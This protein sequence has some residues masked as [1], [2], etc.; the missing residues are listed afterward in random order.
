M[1]K[2][3]ARLC[4]CRLPCQFFLSGMSFMALHYCLDRKG[5]VEIVSETILYW[6]RHQFSNFGMSFLTF[7]VENFTCQKGNLKD[8]ALKERRPILTIRRMNC[9]AFP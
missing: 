9:H 3:L 2:M 1:H 5:H 7:F 4:L 6:I 8:R